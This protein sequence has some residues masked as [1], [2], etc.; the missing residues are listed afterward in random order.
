MRSVGIELVVCGLLREGEPQ[1][2]L[3]WQPERNHTYSRSKALLVISRNNPIL[4]P[5]DRRVNKN[6][7]PRDE[8][9]IKDE[10]WCTLPAAYFR[11]SKKN[12]NLAGSLSSNTRSYTANEAIAW[13]VSR[14][15]LIR[16]LLLSEANNAACFSRHMGG[17]MLVQEDSDTFCFSPPFF[18]HNKIGSR[19]Y[20]VHRRRIP[21]GRQQ[22]SYRI[23]TACWGA[24]GEEQQSPITG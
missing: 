11:S 18:F 1:F 10:L 12:L 4:W 13:R 24:S 9:I 3:S 23:I 22:K 5:T 7:L 17:N 6:D 14:F 8:W 21:R 15:S 19:V 16:S 20:Q 2:I